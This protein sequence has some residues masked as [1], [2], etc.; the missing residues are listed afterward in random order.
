MNTAEVE[1]VEFEKLIDEIES[2][3]VTLHTQTQPSVENKISG[4]GSS[5]EIKGAGIKENIHS[6]GSLC[7]LSDKSWQALTS[8]LRD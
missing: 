2:V 7:Q 1:N 4:L 6:T 5:D 3:M 8:G